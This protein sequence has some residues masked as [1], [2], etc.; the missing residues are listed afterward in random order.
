MKARTHIPKYHG[1]LY[2]TYFSYFLAQSKSNL[3]GTSQVHRWWCPHQ[4]W[5]RN[6]LPYWHSWEKKYMQYHYHF[7]K[8][9]YPSYN[10]EDSAWHRNDLPYNLEDSGFDFCNIKKLTQN[11]L[12]NLSHNNRSGRH[13]WRCG[14]ENQLIILDC[15]YLEVLCTWCTILKKSAAGFK[16]QKMYILGICWWSEGVSLVG[17]HC[18]QD[19]HQQRC[20]ICRR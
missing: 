6:D 15:I 20:H 19:S 7:C 12:A 9:R 2:T 10:L 8:K 17:S 18:P 3:Y 13:R 1:H 11:W 5:H 14:L 16:I 4:P